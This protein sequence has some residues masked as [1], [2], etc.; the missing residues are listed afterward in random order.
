MVRY[1]ACIIFVVAVT[2]CDQY[3]ADSKSSDIAQAE[4]RSTWSRVIKAGLFRVIRSGGVVDSPSSSTGKAIAKPVIELVKVTDRI[5]L[6]Q[7][8]HMSL[9]YRIGNIPGDVSWLDL[10]RVLQHPQM[11]L[12]D[13]ST[14]TGSDYMIKGRVNAGQITAY[15]GYG[16]NEDY[17]M[18]EGEWV[19]QIW[20]EDKKMI[21]QKFTTYR[22]D[23]KAIAGLMPL[24]V[25]NKRATNLAQ[26]SKQPFNK[27]GWPR[28]TF[29]IG[30]IQ[31]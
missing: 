26:S 21:E 29:D 5:P 20:Y 22:P 25:P 9:Q 10:R 31:D 2:G 30:E 23:D 1:L 4:T 28:K 16:L 15:T 8:A 19:F 11:T 18:V 3:A 12:P 17:E 6:I 24:L 27:L 14:T 13:G 7:D